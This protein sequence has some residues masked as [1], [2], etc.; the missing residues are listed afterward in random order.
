MW[1]QMNTQGLRRSNTKLETNLLQSP[2]HQQQLTLRPRPSHT[3]HTNFKKRDAC[4]TN[5]HEC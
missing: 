5:K 4:Q 3:M 2:H 1:L